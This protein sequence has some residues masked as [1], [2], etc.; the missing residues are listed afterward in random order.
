V[1]HLTAQ[2]LSSYMDGE[3]NEVS[4][5]LVRRHMSLC[6]ECTLK[7]AALEEQEE[8]L[9][10]ALVHEPG[11]EFFHR[12]A[13]DVEL[14]LPTGKEWKRG[15]ASSPAVRAAAVRE[16][17]RDSG[18]L[19][20]F[21][22]EEDAAVPPA[23]VQAPIAPAAPPP[24]TP[25][26][27]SVTED[28][29]GDESGFDD[30]VVLAELSAGRPASPEPPIVRPRLSERKAPAPQTRTAPR[31]AQRRPAVR[32]PAPSVPW[33][34][35]A[36]LALIAGAAGVVVSHTDPVSAWLDAHNLK[37]LLPGQSATG[38]STSSSEIPTGQDSSTQES[39]SDAGGGVASAG[40]GTS[41]AGS[42]E[43]FE[44][45]PQSADWFLPPASSAI[46]RDPFVD[47]PPSSL[48]QVRAAQRSKAAADASPSAARYEAAAA[49][50]ERTIPLLRGTRQQSLGR[51][52]LASSRYRAW[53]NA[54]T[55]GR[56][57]A[58][59]AAIRTYLTLAPSGAPRD[60]VK[61]WLARVS[62]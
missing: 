21:P 6:E 35:A 5:E 59:A 27:V 24:S 50:W 4:T 16:A 17:A 47:L 23:P 19:A 43:D 12:F 15:G 61:N 44:P 41:D 20:P 49:E 36:I 29:E 3:L 56:A 62:R 1:I 8:R 18:A 58:A 52:E 28:D 13:A 51:L 2:Q 7:F 14:Q 9:S 34:A 38:V 33:Y 26:H 30:D 46:G 32:R 10:H 60:L 11:D 40:D 54:P 45:K 22:I 55:E 25:A 37:S 57:A 42:D 48:A 53:E 39:S 31:P